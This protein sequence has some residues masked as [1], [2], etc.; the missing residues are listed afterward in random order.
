VQVFTYSVDGQHSK[1]RITFSDG[2][3][4]QAPV[5]SPYHGL[6]YVD[7]ETGGVRKLTL[8]TDPMPAG[9]PVR[10]VSCTL[11]YDDVSV[12]GNL[13]LLPVFAQLEVQLPKRRVARNDIIFRSYQRFGTRSRIVSLGSPHS[14]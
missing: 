3:K 4:Y 7:Y 11:E 12:A 6:V 2:Q 10:R 14:N 5:F 1:Y 8:E 13:Y 9:Y